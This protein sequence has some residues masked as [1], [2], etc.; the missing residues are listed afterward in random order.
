MF[1]GIWTHLGDKV[2]VYLGV[3]CPFRNIYTRIGCIFWGGRGLRAQWARPLLWAELRWVPHCDAAHGGAAAARRGC[4]GG[5]ETG[6]PP[7]VP[8]PGRCRHRGA[9]S[10]RMGGSSTVAITGAAQGKD[11]LLTFLT[12]YFGKHF[13]FLK[14]RLDHTLPKNYSDP[15]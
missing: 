14:A 13:G 8:R 10:Q 1:L 11:E 2:A 6:G 9:A 12:K 4:P 5:K 7:P 3:L 15:E